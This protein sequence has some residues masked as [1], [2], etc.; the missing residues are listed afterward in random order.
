MWNLENKFTGWTDV[1]L[2][3]DGEAQAARAGGL[4]AGNSLGFDVA[5]TSL[6]RRAIATLEIIQRT[7][8]REFVPVFKTWR[9]N[10]RHYGALQ[11][12]N[13]SD[14]VEKYGAEQV[15]IWRRSYDVRPPMLVASD[16]RAPYS[17]PKYAFTDRRVLPLGESLADAIARVIPVWSDSIAPDLKS[18]KN[19]LVV[20]HG[21]SLRGLLKFIRN[22]G[23]SEIVSLEIPT[24]V[25]Y[26]LDFDS[27]LN[28]IDISKLS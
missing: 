7:T 6:L 17:D 15:K 18:G 8:S 10:E 5:Y 2:T 25:P 28:L 14:T 24:G 3:S 20:A 22:I 21:N 23:D 19:V 26:K 11:G 27:D 1:P 4:I 13:K 12:L 9:L 16:P